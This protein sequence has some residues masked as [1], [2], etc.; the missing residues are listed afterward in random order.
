MSGVVVG[1]LQCYLH[2]DERHLKP[3]VEVPA[4]HHGDRVRGSTD[5]STAA[6]HPLP[7]LPAGQVHPPQVPG[8]TQVPRQRT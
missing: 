4:L 5:P 1:W 7:R 6:R 8:K 3:A 2:P